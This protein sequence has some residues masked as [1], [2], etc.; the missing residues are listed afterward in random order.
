MDETTTAPN[1]KTSR[2]I[3]HTKVEKNIPMEEERVPE[4]EYKETSRSTLPNRKI[5][6]VD[7]TILVKEN[8]TSVD[9]KGRRFRSFEAYVSNSGIFA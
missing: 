2:R 5:K 8:K 7:A 9:L 6:V 3:N 4:K 1:I